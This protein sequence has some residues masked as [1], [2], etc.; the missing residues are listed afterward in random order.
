MTTPDAPRTSLTVCPYDVART[1]STDG[2][3]L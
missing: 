1:I 2:A 3:R